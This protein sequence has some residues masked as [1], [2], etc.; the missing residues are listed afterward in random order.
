MSKTLFR[1]ETRNIDHK[2]LMY[3]SF[4][5]LRKP[6]AAPIQ[7]LSLFDCRLTQIPDFGTLP[8]LNHLNISCNV[9]GDITPQQFSPFCTLQSVSIENSTE[10]SPCMCKTL[11]SYFIRRNI[12]LKD[13]FDCPTLH[14]GRKSYDL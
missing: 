12:H 7:K 3:L 9:F 10:L 1:S 2:S 5:N 8:H 14:A 4:Q 11:K 13:A 6:I